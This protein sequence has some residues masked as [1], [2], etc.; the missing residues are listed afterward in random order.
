MLPRYKR[1]NPLLCQQL[2]YAQQKEEQTNSF[3]FQSTYWNIEFINK[4]MKNW[5]VHDYQSM[6]S[7]K[8]SITSG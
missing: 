1:T 6:H 7:I 3:S 2:T 5:W 8:T 4:G